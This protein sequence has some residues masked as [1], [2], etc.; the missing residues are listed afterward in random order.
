MWTGEYNISL[1]HYVPYVDWG[2]EYQLYVL[3][4]ICG[5][6]STTSDQ[7]YALGVICGLASTSALC[8]RYHMWT[9]EYNISPMH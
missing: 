8:I 3:G 7:P 4:V 9:G 1:M 5:L 6:V 2:V